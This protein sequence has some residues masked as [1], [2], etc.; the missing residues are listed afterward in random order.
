MV[1]YQNGKVYKIINDNNEIIYI[2][3]TAEKY[4]SSRYAKHKLKSPNHK[5]ILIQNYACNS[6]EELCM[7]EQEVIEEHS[8]LLN[9]VK[10]YQTKE[11]RK[12]YGNEKSK[13]Y[14]DKNKDTINKKRKEYYKNY[15]EHI[16]QYNK[17]Y[18]EKNKN[19]LNKKSKEYYE[20][21]KPLLRQKQK[22]YRE[23]NKEYNKKYYENNKT[24]IN[25][26]A[27]IKVKCQFCNCEVNKS[28]LKRHQQSKYCLKFQEC[29]I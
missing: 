7:R 18:H 4:L 29:L 9:K 14:Y 12:E 24:E 15:R 19:E 27:K 16:K 2:G 17:E 11:Q 26:K 22:E 20:N 13:E 8:N 6:K 28:N 1:N 3:S 10:A 5:I 25:Q 21:N 23:T